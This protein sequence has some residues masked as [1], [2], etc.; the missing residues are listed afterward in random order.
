MLADL[1]GGWVRGLLVCRGLCISRV[2]PSC[3]SCPSPPVWCARRRSTATS[4]LTLPHQ[5]CP[6]P[7]RRRMRWWTAPLTTPTGWA[8]ARWALKPAVHACSSCR[9][10]GYLPPRRACPTCRPRP[11][12]APALLSPRRWASGGCSAPRTRCVR[13]RRAASVTTA[14]KR[15]RQRG[16]KVPARLPAANPRTPPKHSRLPCLPLP[17]QA[18]TPLSPSTQRSTT[19]CSP[20]CRPSCGCRPRRRAPATP[21]CRQRRCGDGAVVQAG[22]AGAGGWGLAAAAGALWSAP[23]S[24]P[25]LLSSHTLPLEPSH[26][27]LRSLPISSMP[28]PLPTCPPAVLPPPQGV[29]GGRPAGARRPRRHPVRPPPPVPQPGCASAAGIRGSTTIDERSRD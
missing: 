8:C 1:V 24:P 17:A 9:E 7:W 15:V 29:P 19:L 12:P 21:Q 5:P 16:K 25:A 14:S 27:R 10:R 2:H 13:P 22:G 26:H 28:S 23:A 11:S 20:R 3:V 6:S 18:T 4:H